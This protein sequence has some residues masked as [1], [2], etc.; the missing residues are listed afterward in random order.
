M[1][2]QPNKK[3][4]PKENIQGNSKGKN[5]QIQAK[6]E[7]QGKQIM[8]MMIAG[9][10]PIMCWSETDTKCGVESKSRGDARKD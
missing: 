8:M 5:K 3:E 1:E 6:S 4:Q 10:K 7:K 9:R 2:I